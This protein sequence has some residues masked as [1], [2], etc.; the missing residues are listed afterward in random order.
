MGQIALIIP[1]HSHGSDESHEG[2]ESNEGEQNCKGKVGKGCCL[3]GQEGED[4]E[5]AEEGRLDQ[6]Q[7]RKGCFEEELCS[8]QK[9]LPGQQGSEVDQSCDTSTKRSQNHRVRCH[10]QWAPGKGFVCQGQGT[11][12][13]V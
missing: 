8:S 10:E 12:L 4:D 9:S 13:K 6:E 3:Q 5:W 1:L 2:D 11:L 7:G